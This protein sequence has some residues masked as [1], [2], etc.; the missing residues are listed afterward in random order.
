MIEKKMDEKALA[1]LREY[2]TLCRKHGVAIEGCGCCDS[3][4]LVKLNPKEVLGWS[5]DA[6]KKDIGCIWFRDEEDDLC[7]PLLDTIFY[8]NDGKIDTAVAW[9]DEEGD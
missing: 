2:E 3:P 7:A 9:D 6:K 5:V 8:I 4:Y 1:F